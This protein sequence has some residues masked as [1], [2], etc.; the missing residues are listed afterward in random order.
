MTKTG[1]VTLVGAG[2]GDPG[3][4]TL[5]GKHALENA[6]VVLYDRLVGDRVLS[7]IPGDA[8]AVDVGKRSGDH[9]VPQHEINALIVRHA[10]AGKRVVRLKGGDPYLFG[11]GAEELELLHERG[12]PFRVVPGVTSA[13]AVPAYAGIPVTHRDFSSSLHILTGHGKGGSA[14]DIPYA[15]LARVGGT[16]VFLMGLAAA[17]E[18]CG[19]L[20]T[21]GMPPDT[22]AAVVENGTRPDQRRLIATLR[23]L[24]DEAA[25]QGFASPALLVVGRVC[26]LA[27]KFDWTTCLPLWGKNV[28]TVSSMTTASR[29]AT[30]LREQGCAVDEFH[31]VVQRPNPLPNGF[32]RTLREYAWIVLTSPFGVETFVDG[33]RTASIDARTLA[34]AKFAAV[35]PRTAETLAERTGIFADFVP[36]AYNGRTLADE[37]AG[38]LAPDDR[39]LLFRAEAGNKEVTDILRRR[40]AAFDDV[41]AY[42]TSPNIPDESVLDKARRGGYDAVAFTS[43]S[44]VGAFADA[45]GADAAGIPAYCIGE[46]TAAAATERGMRATVAPEASIP[47][48]VRMIVERIGQQ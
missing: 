4:L 28:L 24:P 21:A 41:A 33:L 20:V 42:T 5:A 15:E 11:R 2:P 27:D 22:P 8:L 47:A 34:A 48:M 16:L 10:E 39:A 45:L 12:I 13:V 46:M 19:G 37:L 38:V 36:T 18:I 40:G 6:E 44:T 7:L 35:G 14:P 29:L 26:A 23:T 25:R 9:P 3:L 31:A 43:A 32:W 17:R 1:F 30:G